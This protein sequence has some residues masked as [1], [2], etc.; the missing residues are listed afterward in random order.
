[1]TSSFSPYSPPRSRIDY[2]LK[3]QNELRGWTAFRQFEEEA[4]ARFYTAQ[5]VAQLNLDNPGNAPSSTSDWS[6]YEVNVLNGRLIEHPEPGSTI[7]I[8]Y[9]L[10]RPA[11]YPNNQ[12]IKTFLPDLLPEHLTSPDGIQAYLNRVEQIKQT[13]HFHEET[14]QYRYFDTTAPRIPIIPLP[15]GGSRSSLPIPLPTGR[16]ASI[17][18]VPVST[19]PRLAGIP[20]R[21]FNHQQP[22]VPSAS[23]SSTSRIP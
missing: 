18:R 10:N 17:P 11:A 19:V 1:M 9:G 4:S 12:Y 3:M 13:P 14:L 7:E 20:A 16:S 5:E 21:D 23:S 15:T 6:T 8:R 22:T 2:L